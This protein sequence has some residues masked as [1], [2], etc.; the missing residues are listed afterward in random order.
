MDHT[1]LAVDDEENVL[2]ALERLFR[3]EPVRLIVASSPEEGLKTIESGERPT[4]VISDQLM[5]GM[6]GSEF[7]SHVKEAL[8][9]TIRIILTGHGDLDSAIKAIKE[10]EV[11]RY[12][13]K[14]WNNDDLKLLV[15]DS[16]ERYDLILE[17]RK[18]TESLFAKN[19]ELEELSAVLEEMVGERTREL[20]QKVK[21]LEGRDRILE[22][23]LNVH[24]LPETL[25]TVLEV[26]RDAIGVRRAVIHLFTDGQLTPQAAYI[27]E[28]GIK[29]GSDTLSSD[30]LNEKNRDRF[31]DIL[32]GRVAVSFDDGQTDFGIP[33][34]RDGATVG[35]IEIE[36]PDAVG[37]DIVMA[38]A[39]FAQQAGIAICDSRVDR[40]LDRLNSE[41]EDGMDDLTQ[42]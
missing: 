37:E 31:A 36:F 35:M 10:G 28:E 11:F 9:D 14:P 25:S 15:R 21:V 20:V 8:P 18:L 27:Q 3:L 40:D 33:I 23:I 38:A 30:M 26:L 13:L 39:R 6:S 17:N 7:L 2:R 41:R 5:T 12:V 19:H 32:E 42:S 1:I 29:T 24:P 16:I 34:V 4:V 22:H